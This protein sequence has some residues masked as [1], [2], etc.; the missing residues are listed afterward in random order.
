MKR[1]SIL[2]TLL[3]LAR[4]TFVIRYS[5][6]GQDRPQDWRDWALGVAGGP[7]PPSLTLYRTHLARLRRSAG[8][9][10]CRSRRSANHFRQNCTRI[11]ANVFKSCSLLFFAAVHGGSKVLMVI[12]PS[13]MFPYAKNVL[14]VVY[15]L[16]RVWQFV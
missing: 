16:Y 7:C 15:T 4:F 11:E 6:P 10:T 2:D 5:L 9:G 14:C 1:K 12:W 8:P 3:H 13:V